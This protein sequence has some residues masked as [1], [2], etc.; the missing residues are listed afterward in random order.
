[1]HDVPRESLGEHLG[2]ADDEDEEMDELDERLARKPPIIL[3]VHFD[4]DSLQ[5]MHDMSTTC[6]K[7]IRHQMNQKCRTWN[8]MLHRILHDTEIVGAPSA[9]KEPE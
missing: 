1:M 9:R 4:N 7:P 8:L 5:N 3:F 6:K 2:V